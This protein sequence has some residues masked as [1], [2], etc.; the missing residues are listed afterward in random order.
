MRSHWEV[1]NEGEWICEGAGLEAGIPVGRILRVSP[2]FVAGARGSGN[3]EKIW[4][5]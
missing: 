5:L 4:N 1:L 2:A 3:V